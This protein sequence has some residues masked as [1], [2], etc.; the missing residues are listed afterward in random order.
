MKLKIVFVQYSADMTGSVLSALSA[1]KGFIEKGY[2]VHVVFSRTGAAVELFKK[3]ELPIYFIPHLNWLRRKA[4]LPFIYDFWREY[5]RTKSFKKIYKD[6]NPD[7]IY[8]NTSVSLAAAIAARKLNIYCIWHLRE[9]FSNVGGE[10]KAPIIFKPLIKHL[11]IILANKLLVNSKAVSN[12][13]LNRSGQKNAQIIPIGIGDEFFFARQNTINDET[14]PKNDYVIGVPGTLRPAKG[15]SFFLN[16]VAPIL[17]TA[18]D[19]KV[20]ITGVGHPRFVES[21]EKQVKKLGIT[22]Q[23]FFLGTVTDMPAF[24]D[25]CDII[26]IPSASESFGRTV[27]EAMA[28]GKPIIAT[29]VGGIVEIVDDGLTGMLV[30]Y[31]NEKELNDTIISL[32]EDQKKRNTL[33]HNARIQAERLY[34]ER[35]YQ[36]RLIKVIEERTIPQ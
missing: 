6:I 30:E 23:I 10:M 36:E 12:N 4:I 5:R 21:L 7:V 15:H 14:I 19:I 29:S 31:G 18:K 13:M 34:T 20:F 25:E 28:S 24:Y 32:L 35:V 8:I 3:L 11:F 33:A 17:K 1:V 26:I 9:M 16:A 22:G 2:E 27:V